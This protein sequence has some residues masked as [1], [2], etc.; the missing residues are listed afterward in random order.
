L[1]G[2]NLAASCICWC[3]VMKYPESLKTFT[4]YMYSATCSWKAL[5]LTPKMVHW[6]SIPFQVLFVVVTP[7]SHFWSSTEYFICILPMKH[8]TYFVA[9]FFTRP[10]PVTPYGRFI[11]IMS[12]KGEFLWFW[13]SKFYILLQIYYKTKQNILYI[14]K[15]MFLSIRCYKMRPLGICQCV[16]IAFKN[17]CYF[18]RRSYNVS[19]IWK[20]KIHNLMLVYINHK[21]TILVVVASKIVR[22]CILWFPWW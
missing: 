10:F 2:I 5:L 7:T 12:L 18:K 11:L 14:S 8:I 9:Q 6:A 15:I 16:D 21:N 19:I 1:P 4:L 22:T 3:T 20:W 13:G 17:V